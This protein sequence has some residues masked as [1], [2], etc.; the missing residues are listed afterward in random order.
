MLFGPFRATLDDVPLT[1]W[2]YTKVR[3]LLAYLA[4]EHDRPHA[5]SYL[6]ALLWPDVP[7]RVARQ[8]L[9]QALAT[10]RTV[11]GERDQDA[12]EPFLLVTADTLQ[13]NPNADIQVDVTMFTALLAAAEDHQ[14]RAW[15]TCAACHAHLQQAVGLYSSQLLE[16]LCLPD[17]ELFEEWRQALDERLQQ[18]LLG[19]QDRLRQ[20]AAWR[21]ASG[22]A[23]GRIP[24]PATPL[25]KRQAELAEICGLLRIEGRRLVTLTGPSSVGKTRL[26]L[27]VVR[28]LWFDFA[29]GVYFV[30]PRQ[31][32]D[33]P[34]LL[35]TIATAL[36]LPLVRGQPLLQTLTAQLREQHVLLVLDG[37][38]RFG[39]AAVT[40]AALLAGCPALVVLATSWGPLHIRAEQQYPL[41]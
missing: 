18:V 21:E 35:T 41:S 25:V 15:L 40:I 33:D 11:L 8:N 26:A 30:V 1:Q 6:A 2:S 7:E 17:S 22:A 37:C 27:E 39:D 23:A 36:A 19:A 32:S 24:T 5:R 31:D 34:S 20:I 9:S 16:D 3:A 29:D 14:H 4:I 12:S 13:L 38:E 10:L 28:M